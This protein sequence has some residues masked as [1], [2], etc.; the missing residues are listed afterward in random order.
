MV[1]ALR[2][3]GP[4]PGSRRV[5]LYRVRVSTIVFLFVASEP[6]R[7]SIE[8]HKTQDS[9][10]RRPAHTSHNTAPVGE[11][12]ARTAT[13]LPTHVAPR[14]S[15]LPSRARWSSPTNRRHDRRPQSI[16]HPAS[17]AS[18]A[19]H[20]CSAWGSGAPELPTHPTHGG[21]LTPRGVPHALNLYRSRLQPPRPNAQSMRSQ[22]SRSPPRPFSRPPLASV[23]IPPCSV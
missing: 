6:S 8:T 10:L 19:A 16:P 9:R 20:Q 14:M 18:R 1:S 13:H 7:S 17:P 2:T 5:K 23:V 3:P 22:F 4:A 11:V 15:H 21:A 12:T